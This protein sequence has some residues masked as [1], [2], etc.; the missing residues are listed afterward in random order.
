MNKRDIWN[1]VIK[2]KKRTIKINSSVF[3]FIILPIIFYLSENNL[4]SLINF[5]NSYVIFFILFSLYKVAINI[6][7]KKNSY[8]YPFG[9]FSNSNY[10]SK[11]IINNHK[12]K[13]FNSKNIIFLVLDTIILL[14][15][16]I[17]FYYKNFSLEFV[18]YSFLLLL[19]CIFSNFI[20]NDKKY[21]TSK[22]I[23]LISIAILYFYYFPYL[24]LLRAQ[25]TSVKINNVFL[26]FSGQIEYAILYC[27]FIFFVLN[28]KN[29]VQIEE[30]EKEFFVKEIMTSKDYLKALSPTDTVDKIIDDVLKLPQK[31]FPVLVN[32]KIVG[33]VRKD[34]III[35]YKVALM[36]DYPLIDEIMT[37][38]F[39]QVSPESNILIAKKLFEKS[40]TPFQCLPVVKDGKFIGLLFYELFLEFISIK[41]VLAKFKIEE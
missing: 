15:S 38:I 32:G 41:K 19:T 17:Y 31:V 12:L 13:N 34:E 8:I 21:S 40:N 9:I 33:I 20:F 4:N 3:F 10:N 7:K 37:K 6:F 2:Y 18:S 25:D 23:F 27:T 14:S 28:K 11:L 35:N 30:L 36:D 1:I 29:Q 39:F 26:T 16:T 22:K 5:L 24:E